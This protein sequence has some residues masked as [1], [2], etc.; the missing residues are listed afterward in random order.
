M[1]TYTVVRGDCLWTIAERYLGS[2]LRWT[3]LADLNGI[4]HS[5]TTIYPGQVLQLDVAPASPET[6]QPQP[7]YSTEAKIQY[8]GLQ[9]GTDRTVYATWTWD[10]DNT[11]N[12]KDIKEFT[13]EAFK[14]YK[15]QSIEDEAYRIQS[16]ANEL[17]YYLT[18]MM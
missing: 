7:T 3:E 15:T 6:V 17:Y 1:A 18:E 2:G 13:P 4:S 14:M 10:R 16:K 5:N 11:L 8:F 9:A 12:Y